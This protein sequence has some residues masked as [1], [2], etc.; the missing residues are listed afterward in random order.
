MM[1]PSQEG[2]TPLLPHSDFTFQVF[3]NVTLTD[4]DL[5]QSL[6]TGAVFRGCTFE[7]CNFRRSDFDAARFEKCN[8]FECDLSIDMRSSLFITSLFRRCEMETAFVSDCSFIECVFESLAFNDC[9][10]AQNEFASCNFEDVSFTQSTFVQNVV[11]ESPFDNTRMGDCTFLHVIMKGCRFANCEMN[12]ESVGMIY[13]LTAR[14]VEQFHYVHLGLKQDIPRGRGVVPALLEQY[15]SRRWRMGVAVMRLNFD[16]SAPANTFHDYLI[17]SHDALEAGIPLNREEALF[18]GKVLRELFDERRLP[19]ATCFEVMKWCVEAAETASKLSVSDADRTRE[20]LHE[21]SNRVLLLS[22]ESLNVLENT[23]VLAN[24]SGSDRR[25]VVRVVFDHEPNIEFAAAM[26]R[27]GEISGLNLGSVTRR[28]SVTVGSWVEILE[29][30]IV[31]LSSLRVF[32]Y[33][34]NGVLYDV[35]ETRARIQVLARRRLPKEFLDVALRPR[36]AVP[37]GLVTPIKRL[38]GEALKDEWIGD[39]ALQGLA[40]SNLKQVQVLTDD[41]R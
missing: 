36:Q 28:I 29:T 15:E 3:E 7:R 31:T 14:D 32:L 37:A 38:A 2:S 18:L 20:L 4:A 41:S 33:L 30:T 12:V 25:V 1:P 5:Q 34:I 24:M 8:F 21:L 6:F 17:Q 19:L 13:G 16:L 10:I 35:T 22:Q 26:T 40:A 9:A 11:R 27:I 23:D 39:P